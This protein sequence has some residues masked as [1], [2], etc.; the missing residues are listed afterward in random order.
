MI[1]MEESGIFWWWKNFTQKFEHLGP[2]N[3]NS[4]VFFTESNFFNSH[5]FV[6][7]EIDGTK[8][9]HPPSSM[10]WMLC[11]AIHADI[12]ILFSFFSDKIASAKVYC[13]FQLSIRF[14]LFLLL[15]STI[16]I[17]MIMTWWC[18]DLDNFQLKESWPTISPDNGGL[19]SPPVDQY[20]FVWPINKQMLFFPDLFCLRPENK[21]FLALKSNQFFS[22]IF[23]QVNKKK[24]SNSLSSC[25]NWWHFFWSLHNVSVNLFVLWNKNVSKRFV[26]KSS[27][28]TSFERKTPE[29]SKVLC[30][31]VH[32]TTI[33]INP[34]RTIM[35][36]YF[37]ILFACQKRK[38]LIK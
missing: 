24:T 37:G 38:N 13:Q 31:C 26:T 21:N 15:S 12:Q 11:G 5:C 18:L 28:S 22:V 35:E 14:V 2:K 27:S 34:H 33:T 23:K 1:M 19:S 17:V 36:D 30:A 4:N 6:W 9:S 16:I 8:L 32:R 7:I 3:S 29:C 20:V 10:F 25:L